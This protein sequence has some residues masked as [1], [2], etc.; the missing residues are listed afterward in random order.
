[1]PQTIELGRPVD[2]ALRTTAIAPRPEFR[3]LS[4]QLPPGLVLGRDGRITGTPNVAGDYGPITIVADNGKAPS[5][6]T[7]LNL[8]VSPAY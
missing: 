2:I 5:P 4:G 6:S 3:V 1:V 8:V 7:T